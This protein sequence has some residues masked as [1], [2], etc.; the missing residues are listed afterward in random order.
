MVQRGQIYGDAEVDSGKR[1]AES[2]LQ[3]DTASYSRYAG[4]LTVLQW[5]VVKVRN[6]GNHVS[7]R[8][9]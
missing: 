9:L 8:T 4:V 7:T 2:P 3:E 6:G 5:L 1:S